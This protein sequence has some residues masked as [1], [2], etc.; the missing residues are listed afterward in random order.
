M[1]SARENS[2]KFKYVFGQML[3]FT[4]MK[5]KFDFRKKTLEIA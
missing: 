1:K 5:K 3:K 2:T 4:I